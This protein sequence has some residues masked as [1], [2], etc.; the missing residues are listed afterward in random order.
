MTKAWEPRRHTIHPPQVPRTTVPHSHPLH[1]AAGADLTA[2]APTQATH[3]ET[4]AQRVMRHP[5][6]RTVLSTGLPQALAPPRNTA[7]ASRSA[8]SV[9]EAPCQAQQ[10][11]PR[12]N[13]PAHTC[14]APSIAYLT[15]S[16]LPTIRASSKSRGSGRAATLIRKHAHQ[17]P[18]GDPLALTIHS[19][20][21]LHASGSLKPHPIRRHT[22]AH[23]LLTHLTTCRSVLSSPTT[24]ARHTSAKAFHMGLPSFETAPITYNTVGATPCDAGNAASTPDAH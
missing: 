21:F 20:T 22:G 4:A 18:L 14:R 13:P 7:D 19:M 24:P 11:E 1:C 12:D 17:P 2:V 5:Q 6:W 15:R 23:V 9:N 8:P 10:E 16:S 3:E